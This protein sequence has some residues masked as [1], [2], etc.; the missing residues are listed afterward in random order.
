MRL[1]RG[2]GSSLTWSTGR[3]APVRM[4]PTQA[5]FYMGR[6]TDALASEFQDSSRPELAE[7]A[8]ALSFVSRC[9]EVHAIRTRF[10]SIDAPEDETALWILAFLLEASVDA[11]TRRPPQFCWNGCLRWPAGSRRGIAWAALDVCWARPRRCSVALWRRAG[12]TEALEV[13]RTVQFRP[14]LALIRLDLAEVLLGNFV[15]E[16]S[17]HCNSWTSP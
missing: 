6:V 15:D 4:L 14:E 3:I 9:D 17:K 8:L 1:A 10:A 11:A 13:C 5:L 16:R 12:C 2:E 7:R